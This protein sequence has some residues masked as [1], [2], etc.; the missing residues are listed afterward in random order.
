ME[1]GVLVPNT[2]IWEMV[3]K[4]LDA[5]PEGWILDGF[6]RKSSQAETLDAHAAPEKVVLLELPDEVC[7]ERISGR[8]ICE[9]CRHD[10]HLK[11]KPPKNEG[12]CDV[13]GGKLIQRTD[14]TEEGVKE[15]LAIYHEQTKPLVEHYGDK[16][17][18]IDGDQGIQE[19]WQEMQEK[20]GI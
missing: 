11:Y 2:M 4:Q 14:D 10:Y 17:V 8:R 15:R 18:R 6:P 16:V 3:Q 5:H 13:D 9:I 20:L 7:I 1:S 12:V 19:V